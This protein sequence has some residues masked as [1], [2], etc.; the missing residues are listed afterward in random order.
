MGFGQLFNIRAELSHACLYKGL[1]M[2]G[3]VVANMRLT[4][5]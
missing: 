4:K 5:V 1:T 2:N 3:E